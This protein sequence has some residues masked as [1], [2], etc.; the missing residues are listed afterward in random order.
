MK[1]GIYGATGY[2]GM[3]LLALLVNHPE[4]EIAFISSNSYAGK[5]FSSLYPKFKG[6]LDLELITTDEADQRLDELDLVFLALP[7]GVSMK[8][9]KQIIETH[10]ELKVIDFSG[11]FRISDPEVYSQWYRVDHV[12]PE[13][14]PSFAYGLPEVNREKIKQSRY[15]ANPG[16]FS[17]SMILGL[18]PLLEEHLIE[19]KVIA[20]SKTGVSGAGRKDSQQ[21]LFSEI[22]DST[23]GYNTGRHR[24]S[25]EVADVLKRTSGEDIQLLF[26]PH[27]VP[28]T[29]GILS[30]LYV[31]L[32][33]G[34]TEVQVA[35]AFHKH[36]DD[37]PFIQLV[38]HAPSTK[39]VNRSNRVFINWQYDPL[40]ETLV[41]FSAIDNL[42]K[43]ASSQAIQNMNLIFGYDEST[44]IATD[45]Y[46]L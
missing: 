23:Y 10:P 36:Y 4:T 26:S 16:C 46:Y 3:Q 20:D 13:L 45:P 24:H 28:A 17:T 15:I 21:F 6:I 44:G 8:Y 19:K 39:D 11:D 38:D 9:A 25:P 14:I 29:R 40:T 32:K 5:T 22:Q 34:V 41:V 43:G 12:A 7:H 42:M 2:G 1:I 35:E 37:E 31:T 33:P 27:I 30:T 18:Y